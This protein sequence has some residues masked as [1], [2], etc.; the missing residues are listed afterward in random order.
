MVVLLLA[1]LFMAC[2]RSSSQKGLVLHI[3]ILRPEVLRCGEASVDNVCRNDIAYIFTQSAKALVIY[4]ERNYSRQEEIVLSCPGPDLRCRFFGFFVRYQFNT[5]GRFQ[6]VV[7][8]E[9]VRPSNSETLSLY[10]LGKYKRISI[11]VRP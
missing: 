6:I 5:P 3:E 8:T 2:R 10:Y 1:L 7:F 9:E 4:H 11:D